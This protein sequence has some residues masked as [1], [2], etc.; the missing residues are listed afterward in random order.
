MIM[1]MLKLV[2][3]I[4]DINRDVGTSFVGAKKT[5]TMT[6]KANTEAANPANIKKGIDFIVVKY[7]NFNRVQNE[8][9]SEPSPNFR[10]APE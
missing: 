5:V 1:G 3:P 4:V 7:S 10:G 2:K 6:M 9:I 8:A